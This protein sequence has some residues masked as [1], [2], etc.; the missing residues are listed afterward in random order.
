MR[1]NDLKMYIQQIIYTGSTRHAFINFY[2]YEY[3]RFQPNALGLMLGTL[4][5]EEDRG[6]ATLKKILESLPPPM[7]AFKTLA[8]FEF[9]T[10]YHSNEVYLTDS[11]TN[12]F[13]ESTD[14]NQTSDSFKGRLAEIENGIETRNQNLD[15]PYTLLK[16]SKITCGIAG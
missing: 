3:C 9:I 15:I 7:V 11:T 2:S 14:A 16:P 10:Y 6:K 12:M 4:P 5:T 13:V 1:K 8:A